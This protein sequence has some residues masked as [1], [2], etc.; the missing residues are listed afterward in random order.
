MNRLKRKGLNTLNG[1]KNQA[2]KLKLDA[3]QTPFMGG[4][5]STSS[6]TGSKITS[7]TTSKNNSTGLNRLKKA[8]V[9]RDF[10]RKVKVKP[11]G[12]SERSIQ[13]AAVM[14]GDNVSDSIVGEFQARN[15]GGS[16]RL[17]SQ[18]LKGVGRSVQKSKKDKPVKTKS[19]GVT[20]SSGESMLERFKKAKSTAS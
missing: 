1:V 19:K 6:K 13:Q 18:L 8:G 12:D 2:S 9:D 3:N 14:G 4:K 15:G 11:T 5:K 16:Q 7:K 20:P 10:S 17:P